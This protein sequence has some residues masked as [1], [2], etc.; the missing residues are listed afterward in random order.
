M[1]VKRG[2]AE[3][4]LEDVAL[5][6]R[7]GWT[8]TQLREQPARF[9]GLLR[10]YLGAVDDAQTRERRRVEEELESRLRRLRM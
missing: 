5:C 2:A 1:A 8:L 9:V 3:P 10:A 7:M 6:A 4:L